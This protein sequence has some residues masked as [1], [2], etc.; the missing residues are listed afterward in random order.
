M[1]NKLAIGTAQFGTN[2]GIANTTGK[3]SS[4]EAASILDF[5]WRNGV[6]T[7]D[8][9]IVYG[10]SEAILGSIGITNWKVVS[11]IP[12][13]PMDC[14][15]IAEW[16]K[17]SVYS[18]LIRL[19]VDK[20]YA[21]LLHSSGEL[22]KNHGTKLYGTLLKLKQEGVI[23]KIGVSIYDPSELDFLVD[24]FDLDI[25]QAPFN[26]LDRRLINSGWLDKLEKMNIEVHIR[27]VFLQ[28]LLL[29]K[30]QD[31]PD[32][33]NQWEPVWKKLDKWM[34]DHPVSRLQA[35]IGAALSI[36]Q[37]SRIVVGVDNLLHMKE[38]CRTFSLPLINPPAY[39][40]C[41]DINLIN[42][43]LWQKK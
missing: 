37:I 30:P 13:V 32:Y 38:I 5:A 21:V 6:D 14:S 25:V 43:S 23:N 15:N 29:M 33:F 27:S 20:L 2:Y 10:E 40:A 35:C 9:A 8:T 28:G 17:K 31:M 34:A 1:N 4:V 22:L 16:V 41:N 36:P 19:K 39:L 7:I 3:V 11:K 18:S 42:P 12:A 26:I 24:A